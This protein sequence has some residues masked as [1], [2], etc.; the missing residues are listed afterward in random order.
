[1]IRTP[2]IEVLDV[3]VIYNQGTPDEVVAL[4]GV[5]LIVQKGETVII[6]GGNGSG[7]STLLRAIAGT[8]PVTSGKIRIDGTDVTNWLPHRR[9]KLLGFIHQDPM[10]GTCPNLTVH[11]NFRLVTGGN[12]WS[13]FPEP[14]HFAPAQVS[15]IK[16]SGLPIDCRA[17]TLVNSLSG[18]QR[19]GAALVLALC[20]NCR[21]ILL[22]DEFTSSLDNSVRIA[23]LEIIAMESALRRI[24]ILG[25][26]H[27][28]DGFD[29]LKARM[30]R[31][32]S[33]LIQD[34]ES[35]K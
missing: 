19:Q 27:N 23:F 28:L 4:R 20:S 32:A 7:K 5:T 3:S 24:T 2:A 22:M 11:E 10:L 21:S 6:T 18:G 14:L 29:V 33:G 17:G 1:M 13:P 31:M 35:T 16:S 9:A 26:V 30:V 34:M 8:A 15:V 12:W 25:V